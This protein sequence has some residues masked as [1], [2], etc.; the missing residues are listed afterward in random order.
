MPHPFVV[1]L[2]PVLQF[3][4]FSFSISVFALHICFCC[5]F[6]SLPLCFFLFPFDF[7]SSACTHTHTAI[8]II[9]DLSSLH[10]FYDL[11]VVH[12]P[13]LPLLLIPFAILFFLLRFFR[14]QNLY[15]SILSNHQQSLQW[16]TDR[17][18]NKYERA[19]IAIGNK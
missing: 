11:C 18:E 2:M 12:R 1:S 19:R 9:L 6:S 3:T 14:L 13:L 10:Q 5:F 17:N 15:L 7:P 8:S 16:H 4:L